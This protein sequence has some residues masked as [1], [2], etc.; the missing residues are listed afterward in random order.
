[1]TIKY[2]L[3]DNDGVLVDTEEGYFLATQRV[4][5]DLGI[6]L[7]IEPYMHLRA[8]GASAW[9]LAEAAGIDR[10]VIEHHRS[11]RDQHYQ[12]FIRSREVEIPGVHDVV[13]RLAGAH[14]MAVVT[15]SKRR[16]FELIHRSGRIVRHMEFVLTR[17][18][19]AREKPHLDGYL[20]ALERFGAAPQEAVVV[21]DSRQGLDAA[22]AAGLACLIVHNR[23][24]GPR[25]DFSGAVAV[26]RSI[27]EVPNAIAALCG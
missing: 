23:F 20:A 10:S 27:D 26:L 13:S 9:E 17:E 1:M 12:A 14:R 15:T 16:D 2:V 24:F 11:L 18:S 8:R 3:W 6:T 25:Q 21:E 4:L 19:F 22:R 5:A 7:A